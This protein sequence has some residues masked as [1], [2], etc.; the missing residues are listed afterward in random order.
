MK[1]LTQDRSLTLRF[2]Y[3]FFKSAELITLYL[4]LI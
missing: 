2:F 1:E 3:F 4:K